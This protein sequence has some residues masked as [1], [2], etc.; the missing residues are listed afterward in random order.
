MGWHCDAEERRGGSGFTFPD[1]LHNE[2]IVGSED[3]EYV[4]RRQ[5]AGGIEQEIFGEYAVFE[6]LWTP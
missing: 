2:N 1:E 5:L 3:D 6:E 4:G